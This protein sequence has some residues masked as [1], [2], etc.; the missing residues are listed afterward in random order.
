MSNSPNTAVDRCKGC[1]ATYNAAMR[2]IASNNIVSILFVGIPNY[3]MITLC[4]Q[5]NQ[6]MYSILAS[7]SYT[8][9]SFLLAAW[10][11]AGLCVIRIYPNLLSVSIF[12]YKCLA[13]W[14][15]VSLLIVIFYGWTYVALGAMGYLLASLFPLIL[16]LYVCGDV[17]AR[18]RLR[19][20]SVIE[21][22][23][24]ATAVA[25]ASFSTGA[26]KESV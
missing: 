20:F 17:L 24:T 11:L 2:T 22:T 1:R 19:L 14:S 5:F 15:L 8:I 21:Q 26:A 6:F 9:L 23:H 25:D 3:V 10:I 4:A 7:A 16:S 18:V 13:H 12:I